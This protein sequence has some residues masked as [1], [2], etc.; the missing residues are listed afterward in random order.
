MRR[1]RRRA[2]A[3]TAV[4]LVSLGL[5]GCIQNSEGTADGNAAEEEIRENGSVSSLSEETKPVLTVMSIDAQEPAYQ[6]YIRGIE[7]KLGIEIELMA[8][9]RDADNRMAL[10]ST[11]LSTG[12]NSVDV[13]TLNDEM[14][15]EFKR[16]GYLAPLPEEWIEASIL[17]TYPQ[18]YLQEICSCDGS[19]YAVPFYMDIY[20]LWVNQED[21]EKAGLEEIRTLEDFNAFLENTSKEGTYGY[22]G[23]WEKTYS[24]NDIFEFINLFGGDCRDWNDENTRRALTYLHDMVAQQYASEEQLIDQYDQTLQK[25]IDGKIGS[26]FLYSGSTYQAA[27]LDAYS[28]EGI[29]VQMLPDLGSNR[30][31][32]AAWCYAVN[33]ASKNKELAY[34]FLRCVAGDEGAVDYSNA[35]HRLPARLD[36][37]QQDLDV[38]GIEI[39]QR[40]AEECTLTLRTFTD[41]P[42]EGI[43]VIGK[44]FASYITDEITLEELCREVTALRKD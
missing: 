34:S 40:Y 16:K 24:Y 23:A 42:M 8:P 28:S 36:I 4:L 37:L 12:D 33:N 2:F 21:L 15:C 5:C 29:H 35:M 25:I 1:C 6:N 43:E 10:F 3:W 30:T 11:Q 32:V 19:L 27:K 39:M 14:L 26:T 7:E 13:Y 41:N 31:N 22:G 18:E 17:A 20:M 44:Q 9:D 38:P